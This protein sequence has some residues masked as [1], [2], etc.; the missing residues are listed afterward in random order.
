MAYRQ[1]DERTD[2][3]TYG[4]SD[5]R[6]ERQMDERTDRHTVGWMDGHTD[7]RTDIHY[8]FETNN[9]CAQNVLF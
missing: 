4:R 5:G 8:D 3:K 7:R 2:L 9:N 6:T 1:T